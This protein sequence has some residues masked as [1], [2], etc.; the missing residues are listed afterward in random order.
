MYVTQPIQVVGGD[1]Y[2]IMYISLDKESD[3]YTSPFQLCA[4]MKDLRLNEYYT[5][6]SSDYGILMQCKNIYSDREI[7]TFF[8]DI[9]DSGTIS[10]CG[11]S[12]ISLNSNYII[13]FSLYKKSDPDTIL[14]Q[15]T[16]D[17]VVSDSNVMKI[18]FDY[19]SEPNTNG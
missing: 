16:L 7:A 5:T 6:C 11:C 14:S 19:I 4:Y 13:D 8:T 2:G 1:S 10:Y 3:K 17:K 9:L 18:Y 15:T 12:Y